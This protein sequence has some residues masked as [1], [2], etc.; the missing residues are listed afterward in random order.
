[1]TEPRYVVTLV[2]GTFATDATW[3]LDDSDFRKTM[4]KQ[5]DTEVAFDVFSWS[6]GNTHSVRTEAGNSLRN[7]LKH[8]SD[9]YPQSKHFVIAHSH[10]GNILLYALRDTMIADR[11]SGIITMGTPFISCR[12]RD[13]DEAFD[14]FRYLVP[15]LLVLPTMAAIG[16]SLATLYEKL[17]QDYENSFWGVILGFFLG[18]WLMQFVKRGIDH[19]LR[20]WAHQA[21]N[22]IVTRLATLDYDFPPMLCGV[23][24]HDEA[25]VALAVLYRVSNLASQVFGI[26]LKLSGFVFGLCFILLITL[27]LISMTFSVS[28]S[29]LSV[30]V[31]YFAAGV[32]LC[33]LLLQIPMTL[34][35]KLVRAHQGGF[36]GETVLDNWFSDIR[37]T[38]FPVNRSSKP[39]ELQDESNFR[40]RHLRHSRFY[41]DETF[42][43]QVSRWIQAT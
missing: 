42:I 18:I 9:K 3:T 20:D 7:R 12:R 27:G 14:T 28:D 40:S 2:H 37:V 25:G 26:V 33:L 10:G 16:I 4:V 17:F 23:I 5:L 36:G 41:Q 6:G 15:A 21:Q 39:L 35:P 34:I 1:M 22:A 29:T 31:M 13:I 38:S 43:E 8:V 11:L 24:R 19:P 30:Q 32:C